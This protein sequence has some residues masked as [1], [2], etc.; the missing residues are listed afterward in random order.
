M[1]LSYLNGFL[2]GYEAGIRDLFELY[3]PVYNVLLILFGLALYNLRP[4]VFLK[5]FLIT[6][7]FQVIFVLGQITNIGGFTSSPIA[8]LWDMDKVSIHTFRVVGTYA[9]PNALGVVVSM[10][11]FH[12]FFYHFRK[13]GLRYKGLKLAGL[14]G[15]QFMLV[16]LSSSR[17]TLVATAAVYFFMFTL[18]LP[19]EK[20]LAKTFVRIGALGLLILLANWGTV[21]DFFMKFRYVIELFTKNITQINSVQLR[22]DY[23][24][25]LLAQIRLHPLLSIGANKELFHVGDNDY[26]FTVVQWGLLGAFIKYLAYVMLTVKLT[27]IYG[28]NRRNPQNWIL[29]GTIAAIIILFISGLTMESFYDYKYLSIILIVAGYC[30]SYFNK[31]EA[32]NEGVR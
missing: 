6:M 28:Q 10:I 17:T 24:Q 25:G 16:S 2:H 15:L 21:S 7:T 30:I 26:L 5:A 19:V 18:F 23:Y 32:K 4:E 20:K 1:G 11:G 3:R 9:N 13:E 8:L 12:L 29:L 22:L 31:N 14:L 27:W